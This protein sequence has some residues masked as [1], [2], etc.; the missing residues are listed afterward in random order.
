M[1]AIGSNRTFGDLPG[2]YRLHFN[3]TNAP[4]CYYNKPMDLKIL[5]ASLGS[6]FRTCDLYCVLKCPKCKGCDFL[7]IGTPVHF[8]YGHAPRE[9]AT[10]Q[11]H[12]QA[13]LL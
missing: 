10:P 7:V 3:C 13:A 1:T 2:A 11:S 6:G 5:I 9:N 12:Y 4:S 8:S